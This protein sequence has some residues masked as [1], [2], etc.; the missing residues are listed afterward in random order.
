M[1]L[2]SLP[3]RHSSWPGRLCWLGWAGLLLIASPVLGQSKTPVGYPY[4]A[5]TS[6]DITGT[7]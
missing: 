3:S 7:R 2:Q 4:T 6:V 5:S 1:P